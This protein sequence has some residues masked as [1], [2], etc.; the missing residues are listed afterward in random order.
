[1]QSLD[2]RSCR[3][4]NV[5]DILIPATSHG[6][7]GNYVFFY[8]HESISHSEFWTSMASFRLWGCG[9]FE[10]EEP[11]IGK[12]LT[13]WCQAHI[14]DWVPRGYVGWKHKTAQVSI[15]L[16]KSNSKLDLQRVMIRHTMWYGIL[17]QSRFSVN[18]RQE[19]EAHSTG[20]FHRQGN[21]P[22]L[23]RKPS[24]L[25]IESIQCRIMG[26]AKI[27]LGTAFKSAGT[28]NPVE[29]KASHAASPC[30]SMLIS[31]WAMRFFSVAYPSL[32]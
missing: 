12:R 2:Q 4:S 10:M 21:F 18:M 32:L 31:P 16:S 5:C 24:D 30:L 1:M 14:T 25:V 9:W 26:S 23:V 19:I 8:T 20:I 11:L 17:G 22:A 29:V 28:V 15:L 27:D 13:P 3:I 6:N 7:G